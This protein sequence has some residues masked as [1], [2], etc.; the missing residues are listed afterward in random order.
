MFDLKLV[1]CKVFSILTENP[2][3]RDDDKLLLAQI[4]RKETQANTFH[5]FLNDLIQGKLS[6]F[7]SIRRMRQRIQSTHPSLRGE[8]WHI[9]H[10]LEGEFIKQLDIFESI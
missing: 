7:E 10:K 2:A 4:W 8:K 5:E 3:A 1:A 6:H 9:R